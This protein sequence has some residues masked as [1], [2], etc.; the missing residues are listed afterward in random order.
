MD[1]LRRK[2]L[3]QGSSIFTWYFEQNVVLEHLHANSD[4]FLFVNYEWKNVKIMACSTLSTDPLFYLNIV[5]IASL[6]TW[7]RTP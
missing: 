7:T 5:E 4:I 1:N 2:I 6:N 3:L